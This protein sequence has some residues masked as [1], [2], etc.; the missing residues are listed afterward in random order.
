MRSRNSGQRAH[1]V[2]HFIT[3]ETRTLTG[4]LVLLLLFAASTVFAQNQPSQYIGENAWSEHQARPY[5]FGD[6]DGQR[7][8]LAEKGVTF[9]FFYVADLQANPVGGLK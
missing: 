2:C 3:K 5:F 4:R 6:W 9:D 7:T 1:F 8:A